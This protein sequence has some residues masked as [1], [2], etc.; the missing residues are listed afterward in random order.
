MK[1]ALLGYGKMGKE[2]E[3]IAL[4]RGHEI[5]LTINDTNLEDLT[6]E[7]LSKADVAIEFS[8]PSTVLSNIDLCFKAS[9]P[10]VVGTTGWYAEFD[11]IK[12]R[13]LTEGKALFHATNFSIGVNITFHINKVLAKI[14]N[15][16]PEYEVQMEEIHHTQKLDHP[17][18]TAITLAEGVIEN[19]DRKQ[20]YADWLNDGS[21]EKPEV[22]SD[23]VLIEALRQEA[24]PGTHT[25]SYVSSIDRIDLRHEA[26]NRKGFATGAVVAAEWLK[27][28]KGVFTMKDMLSF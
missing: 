13:S 14:M 5:V 12:E 19:L 9:T 11:K 20:N 16:F 3:Q 7:N 21:N 27:D 8:T 2:I 18:G 6:I 4:Q 22:A 17:S 28:K 24:V 26:F 15:A 1:I 10:I 25:V 23:S